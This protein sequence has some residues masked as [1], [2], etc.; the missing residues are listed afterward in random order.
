MARKEKKKVQAVKYSDKYLKRSVPDRKEL[1]AT[2]NVRYKARVE[3]SRMAVREA[4]KLSR[5]ISHDTLRNV[6]DL[7]RHF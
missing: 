5:Q 4:T 6:I 7:I 1:S 3:I 2:P